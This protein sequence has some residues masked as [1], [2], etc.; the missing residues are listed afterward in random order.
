MTG[1]LDF[2]SDL[3]RIDKESGT[4]VILLA[5]LRNLIYRYLPVGL[6][7]FLVSVRC[8]IQF[9]FKQE[10][11]FDMVRVRGLN[12]VLGTSRWVKVTLPGNGDRGL[13]PAVATIL[14]DPDKNTVSTIP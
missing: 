8:S 11:L 9:L 3:L 2:I 12:P 5:V 7:L 13:E 14:A 10:I 1:V 6:L 4:D